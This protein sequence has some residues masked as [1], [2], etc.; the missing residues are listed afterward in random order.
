[1]VEVWTAIGAISGFLATV[2]VIVALIF[3]RRQLSESKLARDAT[4]LQTIQDRYHSKERREFRRRIYKG[5]FGPS[6][7]FDRANLPAED[8]IQ[9]G[10]LLDEL[11]FMAVLVDRGLLDFDLVV[12]S[13]PNTPVRMWRYLEPSI[14]RRHQITSTPQWVHLEKLAKRYDEHYLKHHGMRHPAFTEPAFG[15][16]LVPPPTPA[17]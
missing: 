6:D 5:E 9:F 14:R 11:E 2:T 4:V 13:F 3:A 10:I 7:L 8:D 16:A 15:T 17:P 12:A 1:M